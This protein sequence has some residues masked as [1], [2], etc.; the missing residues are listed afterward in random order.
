MINTL[1]AHQ[2]AKEEGGNH[3]S[4]EN[5]NEDI[6]KIDLSQGSTV[7]TLEDVFHVRRRVIEEDEDG[8]VIMV[9]VLQDVESYTIEEKENQKLDKLN[10][11][12]QGIDDATVDQELERLRKNEG[13]EEQDWD[14]TPTDFSR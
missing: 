10:E 6:E 8:R 13:N 3:I 9:V 11:K 14:N 2:N 12:I 4:M 1:F 7:A 5:L